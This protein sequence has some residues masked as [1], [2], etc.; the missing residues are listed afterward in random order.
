MIAEPCEP[1]RQRLDKWL[2]YAR[3]AKTR[4]RASRMCLE[5][6]VRV[7][8]VRTEKPDF[9]LKPGDVL[10]FAQGNRIRVVEV[11]GLPGRRASADEA[12]GCYVDLAPAG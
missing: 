8:R 7:N 10:T 5:G 2:Y 1:A 4:E 12:A 9:A 11:R 3:F 6:A